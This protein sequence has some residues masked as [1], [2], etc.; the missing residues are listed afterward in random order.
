[1]LHTFHLVL[2]L[3][4]SGKEY[5]LV[6]ELYRWLLDMAALIELC[7]LKQVVHQIKP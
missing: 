4:R 2:I 7:F 6:D 3:G 5:R 1:M